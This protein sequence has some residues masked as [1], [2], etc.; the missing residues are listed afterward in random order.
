MTP[1]GE[2]HSFPHNGP[3]CAATKDRCAR[4]PVVYPLYEFLMNSLGTPGGEDPTTRS[5]IRI[6]QR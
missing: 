6:K 5:A 2:K 1:A 3:A 4:E